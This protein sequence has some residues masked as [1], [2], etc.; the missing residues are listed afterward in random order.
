M[1]S[2]QSL[3]SH[4]KPCEFIS[5]P[6][7]QKKGSLCRALLRSFNALIL[8]CCKMTGAGVKRRHTAAHPHINSNM[9]ISDAKNIAKRAAHTTQHDGKAPRFR[10]LP[11]IWII[12]FV[13]I[14]V[15][16]CCN[17]TGFKFEKPCA[18]FKDADLGQL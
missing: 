2:A 5:R 4:M 15:S 12:Q 16:P 1:K 17:M 14:C 8:C 6:L 7:V 3:E 18:P 9:R 10:Q 11:S 13:F